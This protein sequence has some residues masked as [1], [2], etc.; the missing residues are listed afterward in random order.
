[1]PRLTVAFVFLLGCRENRE[2]EMCEKLVQETEAEDVPGR[3]GRNERMGLGPDVPECDPSYATGVVIAAAPADGRLALA[4]H[5]QTMEESARLEAIAWRTD[6]GGDPE[7]AFASFEW[8][9]ADEDVAFLLPFGAY[10]QGAMVWARVDRFDTGGEDPETELKVCAVNDCR[11]ACGACEERICSVPLTLV[12]VPNLEG[13]WQ[14]VADTIPVPVEV[15]VRQDGEWLITG[16]ANA[17]ATVEGDQVRFAFRNHVY[18]GT[19]SATR[20]LVDG[21]VTLGGDDAAHLTWS[22]A[23]LDDW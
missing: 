16:V 1:M 3:N 10:S 23:R 18:T 12:G 20:T 15:D 4:K 11:L 5:D 9:I 8:E 21:L 2:G 17:E 7:E 14:I 22:A 13:R 19:V 6:G